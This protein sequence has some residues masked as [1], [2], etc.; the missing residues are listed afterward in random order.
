MKKEKKVLQTKK[1]VVTMGDT[2]G[3]G[4][5][6]LAKLVA[7]I[8]Q[9]MLSKLIFVG[10]YRIFEK[11][12]N[13]LF[14][15]KKIPKLSWVNI[16]HEPEFNPG[17]I[18]K[19]AGIAALEAIYKAHDLCTSSSEVCGM[20]T[21]PISKEAI[22]L[23]GCKF[24]GHT[25]LLR[26]L[27]NSSITRMA[28]VYNNLKVVLSTLHIP[29]KEV[30]QNLTFEAVFNTIILAHH[31]FSS[32]NKPYPKIAV[33]GL[34]PHAG[35]NGLLGREEIEIINPAIIKARE[36]NPNIYGPY[37]ADSLYKKE[38]R[39]KFDVFV[40]QTHDQGLI[41]VKTLGGIKCVNVTLGLPYIRTSV[42]HG[43]AFDIAGK[44]VADPIGLINAI[45][46]A[47]RLYKTNYKDKL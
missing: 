5:E 23:A 2:N 39:K 30:P 46:V 24:S 40:A 14:S 15:S 11:Y 37:P 22:R 12:Y 8:S 33:A 32:K 3:I 38:M 36:I 1:L 13:F 21:C 4:P 18:T 9:N 20:V 26:S 44:G 6:I 16:S 17:I 42:G 7:T 29:W 47:F 10:S 34:N 41:A 19:D 28:M 25:D 43:T 27:T 45:K 31:S 35:E